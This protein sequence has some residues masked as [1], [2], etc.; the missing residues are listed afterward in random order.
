MERTALAW[1]I[2]FLLSGLA[3]AADRPNP[4]ADEAAIRKAVESYVTAYNR[5]DAGAVASH[6]SRKG[7]YMAPSGERFKGP[8]KIR[9]A[10]ETFFSNNKGLQLNVAVFHV[11]FPS[12]DRA[13]EK[14]IAVIRRSG[15][16]AQEILYTA[17]HIKEDGTWKLLSVE[18]EESS[19]PVSNIAHLGQ[20]EWLVGE[21]V[22]RD[23]DATVESRFQWTQNY[24]FINGS[25]LV[26]AQN[27]I[28]AQGT[29][30]IG[31]DAAA[32]KIRSWIFDST[33][34]FGEGEWSRDGNLWTVKLKTVLN[35]GRRASSINIYTY[36]DPN[37]FTWQSLGRE[38]NGE[39]L[40]NIDEVTVVRK[41]ALAA[42]TESG[43]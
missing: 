17:N 34:G 36:V 19:V 9:P 21:W 24:G 10:L 25:F 28:Q 3:G 11:Q 41:Q 37:T 16:E 13:V 12:V 14:G 7:E 40:P 30:V 29:Q 42:T 38:I 43:K 8:D 18:E 1:V 2:C 32:K 23:E 20:L 26:M 5:A 33:G 6:W 35:D 15:G 39:P 4:G 22:D 27:R 31:W